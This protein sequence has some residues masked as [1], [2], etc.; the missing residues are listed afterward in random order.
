MKTASQLKLVKLRLLLSRES[1]FVP[2][3]GP[4]LAGGLSFAATYGALKY[5]LHQ[6]KG[7]ALAILKDAV[8]DAANELEK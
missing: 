4:V 5:C 1:R 7:V 8:Q 3:I 6:M 2:L